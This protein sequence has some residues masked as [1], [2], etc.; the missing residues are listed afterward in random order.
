M[1]R[2]LYEYLCKIIDKMNSRHL[3]PVEREYFRD[4]CF[5][6]ELWMKEPLSFISKKIIRNRNYLHCFLIPYRLQERVCILEEQ[7]EEEN[8]YSEM[9]SSSTADSLAFLLNDFIEYVCALKGHK[10]GVGEALIRRY[11][12]ERNKKE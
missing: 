8:K 2:N 11:I 5:L 7:E 6:E 4:L 1:D 10:I 3:N 9:F 12:Q